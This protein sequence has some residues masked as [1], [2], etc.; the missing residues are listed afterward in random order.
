MNR[1]LDVFNHFSLVR[2]QPTLNIFEFGGSYTF[3]SIANDK[4]TATEPL[5]PVFSAE[6]L[7][8]GR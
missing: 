4:G 1:I 5:P 3:A 6:V 2:S 8:G 7:G